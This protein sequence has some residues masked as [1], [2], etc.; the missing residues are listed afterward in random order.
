MMRVIHLMCKSISKSAFFISRNIARIRPFFH[1]LMQKGLSMHSL[2]RLDYC[3]ALYLGLP[4]KSIK[5][6]QHIQNSAAHVLTHTPSCQHISGVLR[7]LHWLPAH[8][9]I[10]FKTLILTYKAT[11][12]CI[13]RFNYAIYAISISS[14]RRLFSP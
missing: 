12:N 13:M 8:A 10:D 1:Y 2:P 9:H 3:N 5:C 11:R 4:A 6:L 14:L 7:N